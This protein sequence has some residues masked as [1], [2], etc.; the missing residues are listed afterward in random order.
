MDA[1]CTEVGPEIF[2][3]KVGASNAEAKAICE[4]CPVKQECLDLALSLPGRV[5][6]VWGGTSETERRE[7]QVRKPG[8]Q[9]G[10]DAKVGQLVTAGF[11]NSEIADE[12][13]ISKRTV[14]RARARLLAKQQ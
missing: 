13:G 9:P 7:L 5:A 4:R 12:L 2:F 3:P 6:G 8:R 1:A 14:E 10:F 11:T